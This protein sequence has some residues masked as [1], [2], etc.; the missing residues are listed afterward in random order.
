MVH[1]QGF[2]AT[3]A[4]EESLSRAN[5]IAG[6]P[7]PGEGTLPPLVQCESPPTLG[8]PVIVVKPGL[9]NDFLVTWASYKSITTALKTM[10][11]VKLNPSLPESG[12]MR[13]QSGL[14]RLVAAGAAAGGASGGAIWDGVRRCVI[15]IT[16]ASIS[17]EYL[18]DGQSTQVQAGSPPHDNLL[19]GALIPSQ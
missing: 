2:A 7:W 14:S 10:P 4:P 8:T 18:E 19:I 9:A 12:L 6:N 15:G 5:A 17:I 3:V 13:N 16:S 11:I 1:G